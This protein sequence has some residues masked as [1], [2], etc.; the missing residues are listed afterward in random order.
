MH[1]SE[2][3]KMRLCMMINQYEKQSHV[4]GVPIAIS[5]SLRI[6]PYTL[7]RGHQ[8]SP[9]AGAVVFITAV[10]NIKSISRQPSIFRSRV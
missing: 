6:S 7:M 3:A 4:L 8:R 9:A 10:L 1:P 2:L 5:G